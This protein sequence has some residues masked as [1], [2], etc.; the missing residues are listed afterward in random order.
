MMLCLFVCVS[1][2]DQVSVI[3]RSSGKT[4][5]GGKIVPR[6]SRRHDDRRNENQECI[7]MR[8][9]FLIDERRVHAVFDKS[10]LVLYRFMDNRIQTMIGHDLQVIDH[11]LILRFEMFIMAHGIG[12]LLEAI[13]RT[14]DDLGEFRRRD[15][16]FT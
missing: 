7:Q 13:L 5:A 3:I 12:I 10:G 1:K 2:F 11:Q 6:K 15:D 14:A 16:L 4:N 8:R 9:A